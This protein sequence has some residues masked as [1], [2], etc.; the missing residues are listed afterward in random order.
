MCLFLRY[1]G[2]LWRFTDADVIFH[3][4]LVCTYHAVVRFIVLFLVAEFC[5][6]DVKFF[7]TVFFVVYFAFLV[8]EFFQLF[9]V[10]V[11]G[12]G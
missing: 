11:S 4:R 1:F 2:L 10:C 12:G 6:L 9:Y 7:F 8:V 5:V 3:R